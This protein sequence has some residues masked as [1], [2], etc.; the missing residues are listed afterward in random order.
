MIECDGSSSGRRLA[1]YLCDC[2]SSRIR[3]RVVYYCYI[4]FILFLTRRLFVVAAA[5]ASSFAGGY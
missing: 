2:S 4:H 1:V 3:V 5:A